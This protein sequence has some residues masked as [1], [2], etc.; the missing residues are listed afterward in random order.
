M[1]RRE[2]ATLITD[3][4]MSLEEE[5]HI[6]TVR[7]VW[8][9]SIRAF[10]VVLCGVFLMVRMPLLWLWLPLIGVGMAALPWLAVTMANDRLPRRRGVFTRHQR[11]AR[12]LPAPDHR[13]IDSE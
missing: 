9:M 7:Y 1:G 12:T 5:R 11:R 3:V 4:S 10:L 8:M 6:R 13:M 2:K